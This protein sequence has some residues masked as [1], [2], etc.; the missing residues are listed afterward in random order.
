MD[1][2][3]WASNMRNSDSPPLTRGR[4]TQ[5][6]KDDN[7]KTGKG[8]TPGGGTAQTGTAGLPSATNKTK[9]QRTANAK[10]L[11]KPVK[12]RSDAPDVHTVNFTTGDTEDTA[13]A[14]PGAPSIN[15]IS[16]D[17]AASVSLNLTLSSAC[18]VGVGTAKCSRDGCGDVVYTACP[19]AA[20]QQFL[21]YEHRLTTE[22]CGEVR[23]CVCS[24]DLTSCA[25]EERNIHVNSCLAASTAAAPVLP[26]GI[27]G[28]ELI[29]LSKV[30]QV[31]HCTASVRGVDEMNVDN[32]HIDG[33]SLA[34]TLGESA[35]V[36]GVAAGYF[37]VCPGPGVDEVSDAVTVDEAAPAAVCESAA[38]GGDATVSL[39]P[40]PTAH[41]HSGHQGQ[42]VSDC[43]TNNLACRDS[44]RCESHM[45]LPMTGLPGG[46]RPSGQPTS[47]DTSAADVACVVSVGLKF[48]KTK[49][50][51]A[52]SPKFHP[53][54]DLNGSWPGHA[55]NATLG[56]VGGVQ[57][58][59]VAGKP[60]AMRGCED[61]FPAL[62]AV[63]L[64]AEVP[65]GW[66]V[67]SSR[68]NLADDLVEGS[69][70]D[71]SSSESEAVIVEKIDGY[72]LEVEQQDEMEGNVGKSVRLHEEVNGD[73]SGVVLEE[74]FA[75][76][77][78]KRPAE[79]HTHQSAS[80]PASLPAGQLTNK[81]SQKAQVQSKSSGAVGGMTKLK[82]VERS[83]SLKN[84]PKEQ[85]VLSIK[86]QPAVVVDV[87][88]SDSTQTGLDAKFID[89]GLRMAQNAEWRQVTTD[90]RTIAFCL[91]LQQGITAKGRK[92]FFFIS[93]DTVVK[94]TG[95]GR[96]DASDLVV[97]LAE[98]D[99]G[100]ND[101]GKTY[102]YVNPPVR[103]VGEDLVLVK[104][105]FTKYGTD[106][107]KGNF[108][109]TPE[110][111]FY[112][113]VDTPVRSP[114][115]FHA[116]LRSLYGCTLTLI[117]GDNIMLGLGVGSKPST[118][119]VGSLHHFAVI[120]EVMFLPDSPGHASGT[121]IPPSYAEDLKKHTRADWAFNGPNDREVTQAAWR[122]VRGR[123]SRD[124]GD[125]RSVVLLVM[126]T[127]AL[128]A[129][130]E[131]RSAD[132]GNKEMAVE[133]RDQLILARNK[134]RSGN[135][136]RLLVLPNYS[137]NDTRQVDDTPCGQYGWE[138]AF[139]R[140]QGS[141]LEGKKGL[142]LLLACQ[143]ST[144]EPA[145]AITHSGFPHSYKDNTL[146]A[147]H[148]PP[149]GYVKG[150]KQVRLMICEHSMDGPCSDL[151]L[152]HEL[153]FTTEQGNR[154]TPT[155]L[156]FIITVKNNSKAGVTG[157]V[158]EI[159]RLTGRD[160]LL[161]AT[162]Y[163]A[164][165]R[166]E[167]Q[168]LPEEV[169]GVDHARYAPAFHQNLSKM[170]AASFIDGYYIPWSTF[171]DHGASKTLLLE[172]SA[173]A[174]DL[175][176]LLMDKVLGGRAP[177]MAM[178]GNGQWRVAHVG[179][180]L[181]LEGCLF[182]GAVEAG[183]GK[184][185]TAHVSGF[186][187]G[188]CLTEGELRRFGRWPARTH[189]RT[190]GHFP[191]VQGA[192]ARP[193]LTWT[194]LDA[195]LDFLLVEPAFKEYGLKEAQVKGG[196]KIFIDTLWVGAR[197]EVDSREAALKVIVAFKTSKRFPHTLLEYEDSGVPTSA[198][199]FF[200]VVSVA[201]ASIAAAY[202]NAM[203]KA[204]EDMSNK[205]PQMVSPTCVNTTTTPLSAFPAHTGWSTGGF[206]AAAI[207]G[208][209]WPRVGKGS[210][211]IRPA[212]GPRAKATTAR[213]G[214][215]EVVPV[216]TL[217]PSTAFGLA[218]Q[219]RVSQEAQV[220][221]SPSEEQL[222]GW[223]KRKKRN[224]KKPLE[225]VGENWEAEEEEAL[226]AMD[227]RELRK[228]KRAQAIEK[229]QT[230]EQRPQG[231]NVKRTQEK[232]KAAAGKKAGVQAAEAA[233]KVAEG[234]VTA[235]AT[236]K[237]AEAK[238]GQGIVKSF[239]VF[240]AASRGAVK[241]GEKHLTA[242][243]VT[244]SKQPKGAHVAELQRDEEDTGLL[245]GGGAPRED[246]KSE[247]AVSYEEAGLETTCKAT[248]VEDEQEEDVV[249]TGTKSARL[250]CGA[251][252]CKY[253]NGDGRPPPKC[254][255]CPELRHNEIMGCSFKPPDGT[256]VEDEPT[257]CLECY[258]RI[259]DRLRHAEQQ[260]LHQ[261]VAEVS[262]CKSC[263]LV[264]VGDS[265]LAGCC[266]SC[267]AIKDTQDAVGDWG[268]HQ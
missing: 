230:E 223:K 116:P 88:T 34:A 146:C 37:S 154:W 95:A 20:C 263:R 100:S 110:A 63:S 190:P 54:P 45:D 254:R 151:P 10:P 180:G 145:R 204:T 139:H 50:S 57:L 252:G 150:H 194:G 30:K 56:K 160:M 197:F 201:S 149:H 5:E 262:Y 168:F 177:Q 265:G 240:T 71:S 82:V 245:V 113:K 109:K 257:V 21:C 253:G 103:Y 104:A 123:T 80:Q 86:G 42:A 29:Q 58:Q 73:N 258:N 237:E 131:A 130:R 87:R 267:L 216:R 159:K 43:F 93:G 76:T 15:S 68:R 79:Q 169:G 115:V 138:G 7:K 260:R 189:F 84:V 75:G 196:V 53:A 4:K 241:K 183:N 26:C 136:F 175:A 170:F 162:H 38:V 120:R 239:A 119:K 229:E 176:G 52:S 206:A 219:S 122:F 96:F 60:L 192:T 49:T 236:A 153:G 158:A 65:A 246:E 46:Y 77:L 208:P 185:G 31:A 228:V 135:G 121:H 199:P 178:V 209:T 186:P 182:L 268:T 224:R 16:E 133:A 222:E 187:V 17:E 213:E 39:C 23:C 8:E 256:G 70:E 108:G 69:W 41:E 266:L 32:I 161:G 99:E 112:C 105:K 132:S 259:V 125:Y 141:M 215:A 55:S 251:A 181:M 14:S 140:A 47:T 22:C 226:E 61:D 101:P 36:G 89:K 33:A 218:S 144:M 207:Q 157:F 184:Q 250:V 225:V 28:M 217:K 148:I 235:A 98:R 19:V 203:V 48:F 244:A 214:E 35:A 94:Y 188:G 249:C 195:G 27:S 124:M 118:Q 173:S 261:P 83:E 66:T 220:G 142:V 114:V 11:M 264:L 78:A 129:A 179:E 242:A 164:F 134:F 102:R 126:E 128:R 40:E 243:C 59:V 152:V 3:L 167:V 234:Q 238:Q 143:S 81:T 92:T 247:G 231:R 155:L 166:F 127:L 232:Q 106:E 163:E 193:G 74:S 64:R 1:F 13:G 172:P 9:V 24:R 233:K 85:Q 18:D 117:E 191:R 248:E 72:S 44:Q 97:G 212:E 25:V 156:D 6:K 62:P 198:V 171:L 147:L 90:G 255:D 227:S 111:R 210:T 205:L 221:G 67:P 200:P 211:A 202:V 51:G 107:A 2:E 12:T 174:E 137:S 165:S 91:G